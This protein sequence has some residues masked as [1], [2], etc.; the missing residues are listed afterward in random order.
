QDADFAAKIDAPFDAGKSPSC[1]LRA[2]HRALAARRAS[3][4]R[5]LS[6]V[7][8]HLTAAYLAAFSLLKKPLTRLM[9]AT[10][11]IF[12]LGFNLG[13]ICCIRSSSIARISTSPPAASSLGRL[14]CPI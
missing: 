10:A 8:A 12:R 13:L 3:R 14:S 5:F 7:A 1:R 11:R 2:L 6:S 4:D 9:R